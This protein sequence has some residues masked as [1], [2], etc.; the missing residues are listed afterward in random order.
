MGPTLT[1]VTQSANIHAKQ[2][3]C[4]FI[5]SSDYKLTQRQESHHI[6]PVHLVSTL[7]IYPQTGHLTLQCNNILLPKSCLAINDP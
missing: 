5:E 6:E 4:E 2:S 1:P 3:A 7:N